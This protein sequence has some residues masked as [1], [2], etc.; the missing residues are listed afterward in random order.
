MKPNG[1]ATA[2]PEFIRRLKE[3][4][5]HSG[6]R[7]AAVAAQAEISRA[8]LS[9][10]LSGERGVPAVGIITRLE[11][12]LDVQPRGL[13][14]DAAGLHDSVVANV[15]RKPRGREMLRA[16]VPLSDREMEIVLSVAT[17]LARSRG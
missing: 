13:L 2:P 6:L 16:V 12:V 10:L 9:R 4:I 14:F 7:P 1:A 11:E 17:G 5:Q 8:H 15:L 3:S